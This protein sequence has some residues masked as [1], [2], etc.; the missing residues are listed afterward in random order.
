MNKTDNTVTAASVCE[1]LLALL[2]TYKAHMMR[3]A[4]DY[5]LTMQ[6]LS[7]L[8]AMGEGYGT[9]GKLAQCLHCDASNVTGIIDRLVA[10]HLVTRQED[11]NDRRVKTV[12]LTKQG[13]AIIKQI[14]TELPEKLGCNELSS[15]ELQSLHTIIT[16]LTAASK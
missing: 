3:I 14:K 9:M 4:D 5:G 11:P 12:E 7:T 10:L 6:Q 15:A 16:K 8:H 13:C 2:K 1:E